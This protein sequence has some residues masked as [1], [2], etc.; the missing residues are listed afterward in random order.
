MVEA[1]ADRRGMPT[2]CKVLETITLDETLGRYQDE[3]VPRKGRQ[4]IETIIINAF[5]RKAPFSRG[6]LA[7]I[8]RTDFVEYPDIRLTKEIPATLNRL[9][10]TLPLTFQA[11]LMGGLL[12]LISPCPFAQFYLQTPIEPSGMNT[13]A[14][15]HRTHREHRAILKHKR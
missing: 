5:L 11:T 13:K 14:A 15:A 1:E 8:G 7:E 2:H 12:A 6:A 3:I 9:P 10:K 4:G